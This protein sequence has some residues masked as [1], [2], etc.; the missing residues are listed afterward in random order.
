M[1][2]SSDG[3]LMFHCATGCIGKVVSRMRI[4]C[5]RL[6]EMSSRTRTTFSKSAVT[7]SSGIAFLVA[8]LRPDALCFGPGHRAALLARLTGI[9]AG[10]EQKGIA[11]HGSPDHGP[12]LSPSRLRS[13]SF[14]AFSIARNPGQGS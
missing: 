4:A 13:K 9:L 11:K 7:L 1:R 10:D 8:V 14:R 5:F 6:R 2:I 12:H 3:G